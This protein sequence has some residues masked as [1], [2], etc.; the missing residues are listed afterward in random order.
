MSKR[1]L[2]FLS[3]A[4]ATG[5]VAACGG[6]GASAPTATGTTNTN[7]NGNSGSGTTTPTT[8]TA[9]T[10]ASP[11]YAANSPELAA[12]Q[13]LNSSR[14]ACGFPQLQE[15]TLLDKA[16][17][18]HM[19]YMVLNYSTGHNETAGLPG[20][21]GVDPLAR[22]QAVNYGN[23][24]SIFAFEENN[25]MIG[26]LGGALGITELES[27]PYHLAGLMLPTNN[28][29]ITYQ[30]FTNNPTLT[31]YTL[32]MVMAYTGS[33]TP[34]ASANSVRT[35]PCQGTTNVD[36]ESAATES[37]AP[38]GIDTGAN[39]IGTPIAV[40][41]NMGDNVVLNSASI[42]NA[43][44]SVSAGP[45][46]LLDAANDTN[47]DLQPNTAAVFTTHPLQPNTTYMA[48]ISGTDN[49]AMFSTQFTFTTGNQGQ[50]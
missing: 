49:G 39:P 22:A 44:T 50:F 4:A 16:A 36:Y 35:F 28:V 26:N 2:L 20:F 47:H 43:A 10:L 19:N 9:G 7:V 17:S 29:G 23:G 31:T 45:V 34:V 33:P 42:V 41:G 21:T 25:V 38:L 3:I 27:G 15:N 24:G 40:V 46:D 6:G 18:N 14:Q 37:P 11:Q 13:A 12:F 5:L 32:E 48:T 8:P 30:Q 1:T